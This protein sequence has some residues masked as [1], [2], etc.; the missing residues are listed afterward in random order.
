MVFSVSPWLRGLPRAVYPTGGKSRACQLERAGFSNS[1]RHAP[2]V[3]MV[4]SNTSV[5]ALTEPAAAAA[6][7]AGRSATDT[8]PLAS[9]QYTA[10][11]PTSDVPSGASST[12]SALNSASMEHPDALLAASSTPTTRK[13]SS[14]QSRAHT[15]GM[16]CA[17]HCTRCWST[18]RNKTSAAA[19]VTG[20]A[21]ENTH[22]RA[23]SGS[24]AN[25]T[26][27]MPNLTGS[28]QP[29]VAAAWAWPHQ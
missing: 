19:P 29:P 6:R 9:R 10:P 2:T 3:V 8:A 25:D 4:G 26:S 18:S 27:G 22:T 11:F 15:S 17:R 5:S 28:S 23:S 1:R 20:A 7:N 16:P 24:A 13:R 21:A 12:C 14:R